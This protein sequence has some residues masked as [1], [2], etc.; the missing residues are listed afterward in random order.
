MGSWSFFLT[1]P[2][3]FFPTC[4]IVVPCLV[5]WFSGW[6]C[7]PCPRT[8]CN[9]VCCHG[10]AGSEGAGCQGWTWNSTEEGQTAWG[11]VGRL[12]ICRVGVAGGRLGPLSFA[13]AGV[14][15]MA[16]ELRGAED[17]PSPSL[18]IPW[19]LRPLPRTPPVFFLPAMSTTRCAG[20][21]WRTFCHRRP[22]HQARMRPTEHRL[23]LLRLESVAKL[24]TSQVVLGFFPKCFLN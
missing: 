10:P 6:G 7:T 19:H 21:S 11:K 13:L 8:H 16:L 23:Q 24:P 1:P 4:S 12:Y 15:V 3:C 20:V 5:V 17:F 18:H 22:G 9:A 2:C 14:S